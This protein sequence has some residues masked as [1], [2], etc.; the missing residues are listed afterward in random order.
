[1]ID[2]R[3]FWI[4]LAAAI[5][6]AFLAWMA[7]IRRMPIDYDAILW[8]SIPY[9]MAWTLVLAFSLVRFRERGLWLLL[10]S[11]MALY[12]PIWLPFNHFPSCY[13]SSNCQ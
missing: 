2:K 9:A 4:V 13:Y 5:F 6:I 7:P 8:R 1:M 11:P 12:W 3:K 10:G